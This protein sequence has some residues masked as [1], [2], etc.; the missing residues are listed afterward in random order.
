MDKPEELIYLAS[1]YSHPSAGARL[2]RFNQACRYASKL[3]LKGVPIFSPIAHTHPIAQYALPTGWTFWA[4][5][6]ILWLD[7]CS[8]LWV[9]M[10]DGWKESKGIAGEIA[11]MRGLGKPIK[12]IEPNTLEEVAND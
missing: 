7:A 6:N 9:L 12:Y 8:E 10:L 11:I 5:Y 1:P 2:A 4:R 3:I